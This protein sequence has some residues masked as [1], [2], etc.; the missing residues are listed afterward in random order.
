[1][2]TRKGKR[3]W[4]PF[5]EAREYVRSLG[6]TSNTEYREWSKTSQRPPDIPSTPDRVYKDEWTNW[7]DFLGT[8]DAFPDTWRPFEEAREFARGLGLTSYKEWL[9]WCRSG[10][11]PPDI[12]ATP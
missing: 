5:E 3:D 7:R 8:G 9:A 10:Q 1:M 12:P 6:I 4:R 11:K 2:T